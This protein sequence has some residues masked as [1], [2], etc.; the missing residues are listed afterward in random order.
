MDDDT[1]FDPVLV[2]RLS[3]RALR[4]GVV[5]PG[6]ARAVL[7]RHHGMTPAL[8]LA[9]SAAR[10]A[11][12]VSHAGST[13]PIVYGHPV[14]TGQS[15]SSAGGADAAGPGSSAPAGSMPVAS[16]RRAPV[17]S[18]GPAVSARTARPTAAETGPARTTDGPGIGGSPSRPAT[19]PAVTRATP[20]IQRKVAAPSAP[21]TSPPS[22]AGSGPAP[23]PRVPGVPLA[24]RRPLSTPG[25][26]GA[27]GP[28]MPGRAG[29][30]VP[31][32][33]LASGP[34]TSG[35][36]M[37]Y[38]PSAPRRGPV[39][40]A[41][42]GRHA[43]QAEAARRAAHQKAAA[44]PLLARPGSGVSDPAVPSGSA[45]GP[46]PA[47]HTPPPTVG[48]HPAPASYP[49]T[50]GAR[51]PVDA[52][53]TEV[54]SARQ[55]QAQPVRP[56]PLAVTQALTTPHDRP[57]PG[58]AARQATGV[59]SQPVLPGTAQHA[60]PGHPGHSGHADPAGHPPRAD[61]GTEQP[62]PAEAAPV[63]VAHLADLV[64]RRIVRRLAVEAERRGVRR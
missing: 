22:R 40:P 47:A 11:D 54:V 61:R 28:S 63:D 36:V 52:A 2:H 43:Q 42:P 34:A 48:A 15:G 50:P 59:P 3:R 26:A 38:V 57:S 55:P 41:A 23:M 24:S 1:T 27:S 53:P 16:A 19:S 39:A 46:H 5:D 35:P 25:T 51:L 62:D 31:S 6:Q 45:D 29:P 60:H 58:T 44:E 9:E 12:P 21:T 49:A 8:P 4:P 20:M 18:D 17:S 33:P 37:A 64:H 14:P 13:A 32:K 10:Y 30:P 7:T 56:L